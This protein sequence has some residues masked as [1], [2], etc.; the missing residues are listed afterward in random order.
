MVSQGS[1]NQQFDLQA[2]I[3]DF[4][5]LLLDSE[6][7]AYG[8]WSAIYESYGQHLKLEKWVL[9]VGSG[10]H[11]F[12]PV[13]ELETLT[14]LSFNRQELIATKDS[15]KSE[16]CARLPLMDGAFEL[17]K[18]LDEANVKI[19]L[20]S[21]SSRSSIEK[22]L[23]RLQID[24]F[25]DASVT[26]DEVLRIKPHPDLFLKCAQ[27]L[28]VQPFQCL[29][30]EDSL[31]GVRSAKEAGMH[32]IAVPNRVTKFLDFSLADQR[33]ESLR[34]FQLSTFLNGK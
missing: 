29:V 1:N 7:A 32:C 4:D 12:D 28:L 14:G 24:T 6:W 2:V 26:G 31:N 16:A 17:L 21:S 13:F 8:A 19:G 11:M 10:Y 9:C 18:H 30:F 27:L 25:F 3:F 22:H 23:K 34:N 5:G 20:A 15:L 33:I